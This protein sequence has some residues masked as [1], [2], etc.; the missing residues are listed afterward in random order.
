[1]CRDNREDIFNLVPINIISSK[2]LVK[3]VGGGRAAYIKARG[4]LEKGCLVH[5]LS[6]EFSEEVLS[7]NDNINLTL[8]IGVY[9]EEFIKKSHL[10]IIAIDDGELAKK[11]CNDCDENYKIYINALDYK[12]GIA[13]IPYSKAYKNLNFSISSKLGS[14]KVIREIGKEI[15][16]IVEKNDEY[17]IIVANIRNKAK[18]EEKKKNII[19][20]ISGKEFKKAVFE[21]REFECL[22][23]NFGEEVSRRLVNKK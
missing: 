13:S 11:I 2:F 22:K 5:I 10:V 14:P 17:S 12:N 3:I 7:L 1:M 16:D 21:N 18:L 6:K 4:L 19:D 15:E 23:N 9:Y 20:F 8:E